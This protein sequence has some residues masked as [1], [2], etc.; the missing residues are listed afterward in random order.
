MVVGGNQIQCKL[1]GSI[2]PFTRPYQGFLPINVKMTK[3]QRK[4]SDITTAVVDQ[5]LKGETMT[6][7]QVELQL[8]GARVLLHSLHRHIA[9]LVLGL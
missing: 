2:K 5:F 9:D 8:A 3:L 1:Q 6:V 7:H 4:F